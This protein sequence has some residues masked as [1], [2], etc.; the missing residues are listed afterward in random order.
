MH[1]EDISRAFLAVVE[2]P[3]DA[4]RG[5]AFNVGITAENYRIRELAEIVVDLVPNSRLEFA[6]DAGPDKRNY[7]V[8]CDRLPATVPAFRPQ[9]TARR[10][11]E[12]LYQAYRRVGLSLED[13]EGPR[14]Q[15]IGHL[16]ALLAAGDVD[17]FLRRPASAAA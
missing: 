1:I 16:K 6:P 9:W 3:A 13:F 15:R 14:F 5:R 8:D 4:V 7:R 12:E 11:A 10:G 17:A 2:A